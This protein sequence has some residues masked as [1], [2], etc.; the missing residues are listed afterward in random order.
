MR[1][2]GHVRLVQP[3]LAK[4]AVVRSGRASMPSELLNSLDVAGDAAN[5]CAWERL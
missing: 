2:A 3:H 1:D 5:H 4:H